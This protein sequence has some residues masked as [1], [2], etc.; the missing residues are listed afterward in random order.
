MSSSQGKSTQKPDSQSIEK[1][2]V[3]RR[4]DG[5]TERL[6]E[7]GKRDLARCTRCGVVSDYEEAVQRAKG[8]FQRSFVHGKIDD[9]R[10]RM[11]ADTKHLKNVVYTPGKL[12][13]LSPPDFIFR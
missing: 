5:Q 11:T 3:C 1:T 9:F 8:Y 10:R 6:V 7:E 13:A 12:P 2:L 4:C